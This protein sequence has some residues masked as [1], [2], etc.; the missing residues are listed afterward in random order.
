M[1]L[2]NNDVN[3]TSTSTVRFGQTVFRASFVQTVFI[4]SFATDSV[5]SKF[6]DR[7]YSQQGFGQTVLIAIKIINEIP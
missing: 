5:H 3:E 1:P 2:L 6:S 7:Q 4:I